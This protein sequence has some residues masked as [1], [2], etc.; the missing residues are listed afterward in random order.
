MLARPGGAKL[1]MIDGGGRRRREPYR[2]SPHETVNGETTLSPTLRVEYNTGRPFEVACSPP[3]ERKFE[4]R[5]M[6]SPT[7]SCPDVCLLNIRHRH[8][9]TSTDPD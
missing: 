2:H 4:P 5:A 1:E 3:T 7:N 8:R 6:T 9:L